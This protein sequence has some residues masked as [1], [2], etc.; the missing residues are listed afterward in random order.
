M[1][2]ELTTDLLDRFRGGNRSSY[3]VLF[4]RYHQ[5]LVRFIRGHTDASFKRQVSE[6]DLLQETHLEAIKGIDR[7]I[8]RRELS[9]YFWLCGIARRL[10]F[11]HCRAMS[12]R[13]PVI[14]FSL[15]RGGSVTSSRDLLAIIQKEG[16][17]PLEEVC[18]QENLHLLSLG[19]NELSPKRRKALILKYI[20]GHGNEEGA[21]LMDVKP[22][23]FRVLVSR[24]L[25][26]LHQVFEHHLREMGRSPEGI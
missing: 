10:I 16:P 25:V 12:R 20:D 23:T 13:P 6:E 17:S 19:I 15:K 21:E 14:S 7:F 1:D 5:P 8:Y 4:E 26:Q 9:F 22:G 11:N 18:L 2:D 3:G 24:A